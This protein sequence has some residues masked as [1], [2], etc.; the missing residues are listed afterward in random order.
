MHL[1][2]NNRRWVWDVPEVWDGLQEMGVIIGIK[3]AAGHMV[4][5]TY[6]HET[7]QTGDFAL[8]LRLWDT[9][10]LALCVNIWDAMLQGMQ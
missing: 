8:H 9:C 3:R 5:V 2:T 10:K 7:V 6:Y 1:C 4:D